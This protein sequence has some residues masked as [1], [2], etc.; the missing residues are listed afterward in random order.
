MLFRSSLALITAAIVNV[1]FAG[2]APAAAQVRTTGQ[3]VG[4][5]RDA[6]GAVVPQAELVLQDAGTGLVLNGKSDKEG[7]F[8]FPNLQPGRYRLTAVA[9]GFQP[10]T[11]PDI[12]VETARATNVTVAFEIAGVQEK[13][14]VEGRTPVIETTSSTVSTTVRNAE[15]AK[16]PLSGRNI[17]DFALLTPGA[18]TSAAGRFSHLQRA[19]RRRDQHHRRRHQQQLRRVPQ[20]RHQLLRDRA[21]APRRDR[22]SQRLDRR[23]RRGRRRRRRDGHPLRHDAAARTRITAAA[24][25]SPSTKTLNANNYFNNARGLPKPRARRNEFGGNLGGPILR[26]KAVLLRQLGRSS[27]VPNVI[28]V[29]QSVLTEEAARGVFRYRGTDGVERTRRSARHR[30]RRRLPGR[31]DPIVAG[32]SPPLAP[33]YRQRR[34]QRDRSLRRNLSFNEPTESRRASTPRRRVDYQITPKLSSPARSTCSIAISPARAAS[35]AISR[36]HSVFQNTW[37]IG[38]TSA[39]WT[40]T[41]TNAE[42]VPL[43]VPAQSGHLQH[44]RRRRSVR[45]RRRPHAARVSVPARACV[46]RPN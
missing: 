2:V 5:V 10:A 31:R 7:G 28:I 13:V 15:I 43:R 20:R 27:R 12:V 33:T 11:L 17:L 8:T 4:T 38:S 40:L 44:R 35:P 29:N 39:D 25:S 16:L 9:Q 3:V 18:S 36:P 37:L 6:S 22:G 41:P 34:A 42:R 21:A 14:Q 26:N 24:S 23:P 32:S 19:A 46:G 1:Y 45:R 30:A